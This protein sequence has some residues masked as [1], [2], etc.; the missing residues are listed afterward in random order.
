MKR[1]GI[2]GAMA[3][4]VEQLA[5]Q[6]EDRRTRHHV[7]CTFHLGRLHGVEV[8][9]LQSGIGKVNAAVGT[10]LL[11]DVYHPEAI[12]NTG[13]AGGF[14]QG[15][16][17]GDIV[18]SSEVRHHDVDAVVF[19]YEHGQVPNMPAAYL[20]DERLVKVARECVES[21]GEVNVV[22]GLI[23]TGD[24]FMAC[25]ELVATTRS[26][27]PTMLAAEMEAAAIAQTCHLYGCPFVVIRALS[28]IAGGGDNHLSF[29]Q[30]LEQA[31][32]H[33]TRMV[34]AMVDRLAC[35]ES[36]SYPEVEQAT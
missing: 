35:M 9:I 15:L 30:F 13:S 7:G 11:L 25:P 16:A 31:A 10:T 28:D 21:L 34:T 29:E 18:V 6:L 20:P 33:S 12:I 23:A 26:R 8:V 19:G 14:G 32:D 24:V 36:A 3:Q 17:I 5:A 4:E 27:F 1:I 22:E 2:I